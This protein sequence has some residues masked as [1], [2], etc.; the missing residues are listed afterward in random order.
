[1]PQKRDNKKRKKKKDEKIAKPIIFWV[2]IFAISFL[3]FSYYKT[4]GV[5]WSKMRYDS[6]L[7]EVGT[8]NVR[9]IT[10][11]G[12]DITGELAKEIVFLNKWRNREI[13]SRHFR[14][15]IPFENDAGLQRLLES[16]NVEITPL[17]ESSLWMSM[18][19]SI[20][21]VLLI[22]GFFWFFLYRQMQA[23]GNKA[24]SFGR[25]RAK[26]YSENQQKTGFKDV[27]GVDESKE[28]LQEIIAFLKD[29][30]RFTKL[31][32]KIP[33]GVLLYGPPGCGKTL[34]AK[35][36]AGEADVPFYS[37][38]GSDFVEMFVGVGASRVRDLFEQ[39][40][41]HAA[42]SQ[43]GCIIF[44]D[45]IDAVG[46]QR[47]AGIGGGHDEREQTLNQLLSEM[48]GFDP[49]EGVILIAATN[50]PDVLDG[51]LLRPGRF[52][53]QVEV[54]SP[55]LA[56]REA[57]LKVH[58]KGVSLAED[59][60]LKTIAAG[61]AGF[62]G[63]DLANLI[64]EAALLAAR[65]DQK[66]AGMRE[67]EEAKERVIAGPERKSRVISER[68][69]AIIA[70]H[71][72]GH[73][74]LAYLIQ[75]TDPLHKVSI[76][77]RG[78]A[79]LGYTL[80]FPTEDKYL[81][82]RKELLGRMTVYLGGRVAEEMTFN[83]ATT[84]AQ[85]D[86]EMVSKIARKMV[87]EFGMSEK[88]GPLTFREKSEEVFLGRDITKEKPYSE[89]IAHEI[90]EE[91]HSIIHGCY[92]RAKNLLT[93]NRDKLDK[94]VVALKENEVLDGKQVKALL[95]NGQGKDKESS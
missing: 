72:A 94:I 23:G 42:T 40:K 84:G 10:M 24:F 41:K 18:L 70:Y 93:K 67:L 29:P 38:S 27:A 63:A 12:K 52:D 85:N 54:Y 17:P 77:P 48:D 76:I 14:T 49:K 30:K 44:I 89:R 64:N 50:R 69:K 60:D 5:E 81:T 73:A 1:M 2:L 35:A 66:S 55:D 31:G 79:A 56:G 13:L 61:T 68:E 21:P 43:K 65:R 87:C 46:R 75:E 33:K 86:L 15:S 11:R 36:I 25:S 83:E 90:D 3:L 92:N 62:S 53:R 51:A 16:H 47:F 88:L 26:L 80:Q 78:G 9:S 58:S 57:I 19:G 37:I 71:E 45:E 4:Q 6:F 82:T 28:E 91:V 8:G 34:L 7:R 74:L 95:E 20:I 22:I 39:A 59:I 32:A